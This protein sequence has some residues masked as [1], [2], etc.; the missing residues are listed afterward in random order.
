M[1]KKNVNEAYS[2]WSESEAVGEVP[3]NKLWDRSLFIYIYLFW[4]NWKKKKTLHISK[5]CER[6]EKWD[7]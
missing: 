4:W 2:S 6:G 3:D 5:W 1:G 7:W